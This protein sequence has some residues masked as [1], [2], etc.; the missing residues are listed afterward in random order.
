MET[1]Q[2]GTSS[3]QI[4][5]DPLG[6]FII[7]LGEYEELYRLTV[8]IQNHVKNIV[9]DYHFNKT[10][11]DLIHIVEEEKGRADNEKVAE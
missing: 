10:E 8:S 9:A 2:Y 5:D 6:Y 11:N 7:L 3:V 1:V 4:V